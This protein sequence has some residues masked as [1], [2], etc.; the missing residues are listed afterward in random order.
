MPYPPSLP[1]APDG[2]IPQ[3]D[4]RD[5]YRPRSGA[6]GNS[7]P[8]ADGPPGGVF[9][10]LVVRPFAGF[11]VPSEFNPY[12]GALQAA[13][14]NPGRVSGLYGEIGGVPVVLYR[15]HGRLG[16]RIGAQ[17][18]DLEYPVVAELATV[19]YRT[20]SFALIQG[21][22][23]LGELTYRSLPEELDFGAYLRDVLADP[24]RRAQVFAE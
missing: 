24:Q 6:P 16:L 22:T 20:T 15:Q 4:S 1:P 19:A 9:V 13:P 8:A 5:R 18:I 14:T 11:G 12:T 17:T 3:G 2:G 7:S 10:P 21:G 23:R